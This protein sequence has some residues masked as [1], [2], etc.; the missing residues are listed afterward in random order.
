[1]EGYGK[2]Q[3][4]TKTKTTHKQ[5]EIKF[6]DKIT[7]TSRVL[8]WEILD[9]TQKMIIWILHQLLAAM[10][11]ARYEHRKISISLIISQE[12][13]GMWFQPPNRPV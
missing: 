4:K 8:I 10:S 5:W 13:R 7:L 3:Q 2:K 11:I 12:I 1:M 6:G 9:G